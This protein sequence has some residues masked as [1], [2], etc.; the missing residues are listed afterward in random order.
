MYIIIA[1]GTQL[2]TWSNKKMLCVAFKVTFNDSPHVGHVYIDLENWYIF[3][4]FCFSSTRKLHFRFSENYYF[5]TKWR[6]GK[7]QFSCLCVSKG[8]Q[9]VLGS[10]MSQYE[11]KKAST[12][13]GEGGALFR[14]YRVYIFRGLC[15]WKLF[16]KWCGVCDAL[17]EN[18]R[19]EIFSYLDVSSSLF[20]LVY[21][22]QMNSRNWLIYRWL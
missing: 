1:I 11:T 21:A 3:M 18:R 17:I 8:K 20:C 12:L 15:R 13:G 16:W 2:E 19:E 5:W 7:S 6:F 9:E 22:M 10:W 4:R 14:L